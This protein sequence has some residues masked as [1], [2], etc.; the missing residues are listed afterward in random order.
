MYKRQIY[1]WLNKGDLLTIAGHFEAST[2]TD[3]SGKKVYA[4]VL[5]IDDLAT[6]EAKSVRDNRAAQAQQIQ[7]QQVQVQAPVAQRVQ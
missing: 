1:S 2:Y 7:A 4:Q 6:L 5:R 3:Q